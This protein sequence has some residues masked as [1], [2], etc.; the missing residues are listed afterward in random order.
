MVAIHSDTWLRS[1]F[2][3]ASADDVRKAIERGL[4]A[5]RV[6]PTTFTDKEDDLELRIAFDFDGVIADDSA[7]TVFKN[8][9]L[10]AFHES[11]RQHSAEPL[12]K[13]PL[14][15]FFSEIARLQGFERERRA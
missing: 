13:G 12:G 4:P 2:L 11:E 1:L 7:E 5:G 3:S 9:G 14:A 15:K 10:E 6:F 8:D